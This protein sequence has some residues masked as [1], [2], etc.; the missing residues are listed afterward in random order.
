MHRGDSPRPLAPL[1]DAVTGVRVPDAAASLRVRRIVADARQVEPG[2]LF[3]ALRG[4]RTDGHRYVGDAVRRGAVAVVVERDVDTAM[5]RPVLR[6]P[7][8][9]RALAELAAAWYDRP[10]RRLSLVGITGSFGKT[11]TLNMLHAIL[12]RAGIVAGAIGS[13]FLGL[14]L[15]GERNEQQQLTTPDPLDLHEALSRVVDHG[16][17]VCAMEVTS[18]GLVQRRIHGLE[19]A[20][21]IFTCIAPLEHA[22]YHGSF[23]RYVEAKARFVEHLRP[24]APLVY[25][26]GERVVGAL[27]A[28]CRAA[29][30]PCGLGPGAGVRIRRRRRGPA[31]TRML[32]EVARPLPRVD[33]GEVGPVTVPIELRLLGRSNARNAALAAVAGLCLGA[34]PEAVR[35]ALAAVRPPPRRLHYERRGRFA[36][37]DDTA[38]HPE[39]L[40]V[41]F[42]VVAGLRR[43]RLH[44]V[45][46]IRGARGV[47]LNRRYGETIAIWSRTLKIRTLVATSSREAVEPADGVAPEEREAFLDELRRAGVD[48]VHRERLDD[49]LRHA[50]DRVRD[51]DLLVLLGTQGMHPGAELVRRWTEGEDRAR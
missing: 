37:L 1:L 18:Q 15:P 46:A 42:E 22:D 9:R 29:P 2:D 34:A 40:C 5:G 47:E 8:T 33:G 50:L 32:L 13:D 27:V 39:A 30:V 20:V 11:G 7:D 51:G 14:R 16:G 31:G 21:G 49:A 23:R 48:A 43:R 41:L 24:G 28:G 38:T 44:V 35:E 19:F 6:V 12:E 3:V 17:R 45:A 36:L 4:H 25:P 26:R 10:A